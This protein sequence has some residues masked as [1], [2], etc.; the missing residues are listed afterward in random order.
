MAI[1]AVGHKKCIQKAEESSGDS[2]SVNQ[3]SPLGDL[4][5]KSRQ[6]EE[7]YIISGRVSR[8]AHHCGFL[9]SPRRLLDIQLT[10]AGKAKELFRLSKHFICCFIS[11]LPPN[12]LI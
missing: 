10:L 9:P 3:G 6:P 5:S 7:M 2:H 11:L 12:S 8:A 1:I 4:P